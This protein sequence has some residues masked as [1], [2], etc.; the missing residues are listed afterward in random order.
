MVAEDAQ[1]DIGPVL[2]NAEH[3][4]AVGVE[5]EKLT[6]TVCDP[7]VADD[8][9]ALA[10]MDPGIFAIASRDAD[11]KH[12]IVGYS[13]DCTSRCYYLYDR[14]A[15]T[16][17]RL[18]SSN[19]RLAECTLAKKMPIAFTARD[20]L[21]IHGYLTLPVGVPEKGLPMVL[22][23]HGGPWNRCHW[24]FEAES[25]WLANRGYAVLQVDFRGS[26]GYGKSF[27][28]AG[29]HEWGGKMQDD[30]SDGVDWAIARGI[31]D[32]KHIAI[33]GTSYGGY[34]A[35]AGLAFTPSRYVAGVELC[36]PS[37]LLALRRLRGNLTSPYGT[38]EN[39][40]I[41][42]PATEADFL[43]TRSPFYAVERIAAPV[44]IGQ[45]AN[46]PR[47]AASVT[48]QMVAALRAAK[49]SV[50]YVLFPDEGHGLS[51]PENRRQFFA[52]AE[53]FLA[54]YLGG[55][56]EPRAR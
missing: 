5:K 54:Q 46:D 24:P 33:M 41:G 15:K 56:S 37:D 22:L 29:N 39:V 48:E 47:V 9:A 52:L 6:W 26:T 2:V 31:A 21:S 55:R 27:L 35:L 18:F 34:A 14:A 49:K 11:D 12:W 43:K 4:L 32:A 3:V 1:Y 19:Q 23:V 53:A 30:L 40:V 13:S 50:Q 25:Q 51:R 8:F 7:S 44:L 10:K 16:C 28:N 45:G 38:P 36:G 20:G 17:T 42:N